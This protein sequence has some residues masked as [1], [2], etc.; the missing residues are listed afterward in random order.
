LF[1][2][3]F[4]EVNFDAIFIS[5]LT[6]VTAQ[7]AV[8]PKTVSP[9]LNYFFSIFPQLPGNVLPTPTNR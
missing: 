1:L 8:L 3:F 5:G 9:F 6:L 2:A 4:L 7:Q